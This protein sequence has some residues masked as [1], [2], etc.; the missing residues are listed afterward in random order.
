MWCCT[1]ANEHRSERFSERGAQ[2]QGMQLPG[3]FIV[4]IFHIVLR[5]ACICQNT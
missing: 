4:F 3:F 2:K 5:Y 1:A